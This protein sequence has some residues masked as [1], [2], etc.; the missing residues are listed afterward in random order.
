MSQMSS[1]TRA[2]YTLAGGYPG[3][4]VAEIDGYLCFIL[5]NDDKETNHIRPWKWFIQIGGGWTSR[6]GEKIKTLAEGLAPN[7]LDADSDI[8]EALV[9]LGAANL[10]TY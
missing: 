7:A 1:N 5:S 2:N 3:G 6:G 4:F 8:Y 10:A 9:N